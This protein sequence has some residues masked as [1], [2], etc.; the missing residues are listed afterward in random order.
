MMKFIKQLKVNFWLSSVISVLLG[1]FFIIWPTQVQEIIAV[2]LGVV[3]LVL[4]IVWVVTFIKAPEWTFGNAFLLFSGAVFIAVGIWMIVNPMFFNKII[5]SIIGILVAING[6]MA[7]GEAFSLKSVNYNK[8][9]LSLI[10]AVATIILAILVICYPIV[11][12]DL[13]V[14]IVGGILIYNGV[15][16]IWIATRVHKHVKKI[17]KSNDMIDVEFEEETVSDIED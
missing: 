10:F 5:M 14:Q 3:L 7:M 11:F 9:W 6:V 12:G 16:D 13:A 2:V 8:W 4:G 17:K 15:S 1:L